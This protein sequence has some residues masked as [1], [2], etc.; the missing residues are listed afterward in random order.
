MKLNIYRNLSL[1]KLLGLLPS[2]LKDIASM[3]QL[4]PLQY[5]VMMFGTDRKDVTISTSVRKALKQIT[6]SDPNVIAVGA[7]FTL[8]GMRLLVEHNVQVI[9]TLGI[10]W[11][12]E[13][14]QNIRTSIASRVKRPYLNSDVKIEH[15]PTVEQLQDLGIQDWP[16]WETEVSEFPWYYDDIE[17]CY[18]L[19]GDVTVRFANSRPLRIGKG[20]LVT[21]PKGMSCVWTVRKPVRKHYKFGR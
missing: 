5:T 15:N 11:T 16:I 21:F 7:Q 18:F 14:Y 2:S 19:E 9:S 17:T 4:Q 12:D 13:S 8:E 6:S 20:D 3:R 1:E 10:G